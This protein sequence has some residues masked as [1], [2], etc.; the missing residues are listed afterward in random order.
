MKSTEYKNMKAIILAGGE[1]SRLRPWTFFVPKPLLPVG[2]K[3]ILE[4]IINRLKNFGFKEF[5]LSIG[6]RGEIVESYFQNGSKLGVNISYFK[7]VK[8]LG[9]AGP[10]SLIADKVKFDSDKPILL[11]NGDI[12]TRIN[13][14]DF[15]KYHKE[16]EFDLSVVVKKY[17]MKF[18]YGILSIRNKLITKVTEKP[19]YYYDI[20]AGIYLLR[21]TALKFIPKNNFFTIPQLMDVLISKK[22]RVGAYFAK[23][24]W[25]AIENPVDVE[26]VN[27]DLKS[28][29]DAVEF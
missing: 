8:P 18:P 6:Y 16:N 3:P 20:S 1:G 13:F 19:T 15:I 21:K 5:I 28:W 23:E 26:R 25:L 10:L 27:S 17:E 12:L 22:M 9:T 11:M 24:Q 29:L 2:E 14:L 7:E 4:I